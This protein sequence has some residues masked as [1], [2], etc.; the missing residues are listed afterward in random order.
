MATRYARKTE[1]RLGI[2]TNVGLVESVAIWTAHRWAPKWA[3]SFNIIH[4]E[5]TDYH[6]NPTS[7]ETGYANIVVRYLTTLGGFA[8]DRDYSVYRHANRFAR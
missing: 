4:L 7:R 1:Y 6:G 8:V 3:R 5:H 2:Q